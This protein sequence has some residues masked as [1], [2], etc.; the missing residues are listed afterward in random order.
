MSDIPEDLRAKMVALLQQSKQFGVIAKD[1]ADQMLQ[2]LSFTTG[3][4]GSSPASEPATASPRQ[5]RNGRKS[6][7]AS[8]GP[9]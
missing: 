9:K 2:A 3:N 1:D 6:E 8:G 7:V 4:T 5:S